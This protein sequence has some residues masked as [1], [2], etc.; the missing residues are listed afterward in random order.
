MAKLDIK[1]IAPTTY[2]VSIDDKD[3][4][5]HGAVIVANRNIPTSEWSQFATHA[6]LLPGGTVSERPNVTDVR[7]GHLRYNVDDDVVEAFFA[8]GGWKTLATQLNH[9]TDVTISTLANGQ[10]L[11][12]NS[13]LGQWVNARS[14]ITI[15]PDIPSRNAL[16]NLFPGDC[17]WVTNT[18]EGEYAFYIW[19]GTSWFLVVDFDA[20]DKEAQTISVNYVVGS[21]TSPIF[22]HRISP[23]TRVHH[24]GVEII[25][26][27][28]DPNAEILVG[29]NLSSPTSNSRLF[30]IDLVDVTISDT[31]VNRP[32]VVYDFITNELELF[33]YINPLTSTVGEAKITI[34]YS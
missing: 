26:P 15:V 12:Y 30:N 13:T 8:N 11:R 2:F 7:E 4:V 10:T 27:F 33:T 20:R 6:L 25:T 5:D 1:Q 9:L 14:P 18:G 19:D 17:A 24:V 22:L 23:N 31:Y 16:T 32:N 34:Q 28:D 29:D 21:S 3:L